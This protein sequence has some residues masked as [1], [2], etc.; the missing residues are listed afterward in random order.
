[1]GTSL[2]KCPSGF[3]EETKRIAKEVALL[4]THVHRDG[5]TGEVVTVPEP[6]GPPRITNQLLKL[7]AGLAL[8]RGDETPGE[9][10]MGLIKR[11]AR[12]TIPSVR[13]LVLQTVLSGSQT[14]IE[15]SSA[16]G[17][18]ER[19]VERKMEELWM[20]GAIN[21]DISSRPYIF[22]PS[23][24]FVLFPVV[25]NVSPTEIRV[26]NNNRHVGISVTDRDKFLRT[27]MEMRV[28]ERENGLW[29]GHFLIS[30]ITQSAAK[31]GF[32]P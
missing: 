3:V 32:A 11:V 2:P 8:V 6:E 13:K 25:H 26:D 18:K 20:L 9:Y 22:S 19:T 12:D 1:Y 10:E 27:E 5:Y 21:G 14:I 29:K 23:K 4:R 7:A 31:G 28:K 30:D 24:P 16:I 17:L 15:V